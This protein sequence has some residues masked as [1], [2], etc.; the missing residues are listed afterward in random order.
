MGT[1]DAFVLS[2][3]TGTPGCYQICWDEERGSQVL[4][5]KTGERRDRNGLEEKGM[6]W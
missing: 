4:V 1:I 5:R 3:E 6:V 2:G